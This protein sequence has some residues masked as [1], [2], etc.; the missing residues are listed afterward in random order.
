MESVWDVVF[1][2]SYISFEYGIFS[3]NLFYPVCANLAKKKKK[4]LK[5]AEF[6]VDVYLSCFGM[7]MPAFVQNCLF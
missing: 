4:Q 1:L 3:I 5:Y 2:S 6:D 7:E